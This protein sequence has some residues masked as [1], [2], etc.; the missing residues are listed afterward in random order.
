[1]LQ[2][3]RDRASGWFAYIVFGMLLIPFALWGINYYT[4]DNAAPFAAKVNGDEIS[5]SRFQQTLQNQRER[6]RQSGI[7]EVDENRLKQRVVEQLIDERLLEQFTKAEHMRVGDMQI[8][9]WVQSVDAFKAGERFDPETYQA[10]LRRQGYTVTGFESMLRVSLAGD[11]LRQ[12][13][14]ASALLSAGDRTRL[15][16]LLAQKRDFEVLTLPLAPLREQQRVDE[17]AV[18]A[19]YR[20]QPQDYRFPEQVRLEVLDLKP[21]LLGAR[22][23]APTEAD[24]QGLY[25]QQQASLGKPETRTASHILVRV[26]EGAG[27]EQ[28]EQA[29]Q[30][31]LGYRETVAGGK[32]SFEA[33]GK[34]LAGTPNVEVGNL[35]ALERGVMDPAFDQALFGLGKV[36]DLSEPV[37]TDFGFHV[38]RLD[39]IT[40]GSVPPFEE[41]RAQLVQLWQRQHVE[42]A[43]F[44]AA[45]RLSTLVFEN[46]DN[47]SVAARELG[48]QT[49]TSDWLTR[50]GSDDPLLNDPRVLAAAFS[51]EVLKDGRNSEPVQIDAQHV[52]VVRLVEHREA[53]PKTLADAHDQIVAELKDLQARTELTQAAE[54]LMQ[55]L[56]EGGSP[57]ALAQTAG[58]TRQVS[59]PVLRNAPVL[60][61][62]LMRAAFRAPPPAGDKPSVSV[63]ELPDG[64]RAVIVLKSVQAGSEADVPEAERQTLVQR[65]AQQNGERE[66]RGLLDGLRAGA[67]IENRAGSL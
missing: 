25:A 38:I 20:A 31:A 32:E 61:P 23:P 26:A 17:S 39:A 43:F 7:P 67:K 60:T 48:L 12:G 21:D 50:T 52:V 55:A 62:E 24:L 29:R 19:R 53:R 54:R 49:Q 30:Q 56:R 10:A 5:L 36:G 18:D 3:I 16:E 42:G 46:P 41:V 11:Q 66:F 33:L 45:D 59:G 22:V 27:P 47:L 65:V 1:M 4:H 2:T 44:D 35:G 37:R 57:E 15:Y 8:A 6:L 64:D 40:P 63:L 34:S 58:A 14:A 13:L 28:V 9:A 51:D